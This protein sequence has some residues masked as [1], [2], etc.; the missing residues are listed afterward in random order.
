M[1]PSS[2]HGAC[3]TCVNLLDV[4]RTHGWY[5]LHSFGQLQCCQVSN[6]IINAYILS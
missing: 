1:N 6:A 3:L 4:L 2:W 5:E